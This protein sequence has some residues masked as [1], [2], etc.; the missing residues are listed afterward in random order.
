MALFPPP[1]SSPC[2]YL[3]SPTPPL[4]GSL[5][6]AALLVWPLGVAL[7]P[8]LARPRPEAS[9]RHWN[10]PALDVKF[11]PGATR[12]CPAFDVVPPQ[13]RRGLQCFS[14]SFWFPSHNKTWAPRSLSES[15]PLLRS[16]FQGRVWPSVCEPVLSL[17]LPSLLVCLYL[18]CPFHSPCTLGHASRCETRGTGQVPAWA[19]S[20]PDFQVPSV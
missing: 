18:S 12:R 9:L 17:C 14:A 11:C 3:G 1:E 5:L 15:D 19:E 20:G 13:G 10:C 6:C 7:P 8:S 16:F 4:P 2:P